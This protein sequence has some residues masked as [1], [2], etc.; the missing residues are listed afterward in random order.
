LLFPR[1]LQEAERAPKVCK[2]PLIYVQGRGNRDGRPIIGAHQL[3]QM[4]YAGCI[5][6]QI[7]LTTGFHFLRESLLELRRTGNY[8]GLTEAQFASARKALEDLIGLEEFYKIEKA[9]VEK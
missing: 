2:L 6:S 9:T 5:E 3:S 1:T 8:T 4:G 7:A